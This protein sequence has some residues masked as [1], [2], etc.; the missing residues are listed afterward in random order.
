MK[1]DTLFIFDRLAQPADSQVSEKSLDAGLRV[2]LFEPSVV[3]IFI[4][5]MYHGCVV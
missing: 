5:L 4:T 2:F 1:F 3:C